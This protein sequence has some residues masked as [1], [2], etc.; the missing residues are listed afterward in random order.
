MLLPPQ[1]VV[2]VPLEGQRKDSPK[3]FLDAGQREHSR[4]WPRP[5]KPRVKEKHSLASNL[6]ISKQF[7]PAPGADGKAESGKNGHGSGFQGFINP[8]DTLFFLS[9]ATVSKY[10]RIKHQLRKTPG[11]PW[12]LLIPS[13]SAFVILTVNTPTLTTTPNTTTDATNITMGTT[14]TIS[15]ISTTIASP[16][17][18]MKH[19]WTSHFDS[20][21]S[22][23]ASQLS[24]IL[25][26]E[27]P[28]FELNYT[29]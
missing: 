17:A 1:T 3:S 12:Y 15:I 23:A 22:M 27:V 13:A 4:D 2:R 14:S 5:E 10:H 25:L 11:A 8:D 18:I 21:D 20:P 26:E 29:F 6:V 7:L 19:P 24:H 9:G 28:A 16:R